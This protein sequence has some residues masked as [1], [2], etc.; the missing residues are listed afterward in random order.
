MCVIVVNIQNRDLIPAP[1]DR[2]SASA[3]LYK[4]PCILYQ[5]VR[6]STSMIHVACELKLHSVVRLSIHPL[7]GNRPCGRV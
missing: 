2:T 4:H 1:V 7:V 6:P 5:N 3:L